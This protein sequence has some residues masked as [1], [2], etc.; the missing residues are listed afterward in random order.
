MVLAFKLP[1]QNKLSPPS[2]IKANRMEPKRIPRRVPIFQS[3]QFIIDFT[4]R[5]RLLSKIGTQRSGRNFLEEPWNIHDQTHAPIIQNRRAGNSRHCAK[6]FTQRLDDRLHA[7]KQPIYRNAGIEITDFDD[8]HIFPIRR[9]PSYLERFAQSDKRQSMSAEIEDAAALRTP[10]FWAQLRAFRDVIGRNNEM[11]SAD[12]H[13]KAINNCQRQWQANRDA[14]AL[15]LFA[16]QFDTPPQRLDI[17]LY[18][19]QSD[20]A[21]GEIANGFR[22]GK[23]RQEEEAKKFLIGWLAVPGEQAHLSG[24]VDD[25]LTINSSAVVFERH[26]NVS[27]CMPGRELEDSTPVLAVTFA[28]CRHFD[29]VIN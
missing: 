24:L 13:G 18:N 11:F 4:F 23:A 17:A 7:A 16:K 20:A 10:R 19:I 12:G 15:A 21:T 27:F 2:R 28:N 26:D 9:L 6:H 8:H 25:F 5:T 1:S 29:A 14:C 22:G 3:C